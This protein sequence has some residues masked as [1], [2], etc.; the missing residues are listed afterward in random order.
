MYADPTKIRSHI[1]KIR[2]SQEEHELIQ[3]LVNYAGEQRAALLR[4]MILEQAQSV[5]CADQSSADEHA[6]EG[7]FKGLRRA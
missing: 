4:E 6:V 5:L 2:F 3:A 7:T 1:V